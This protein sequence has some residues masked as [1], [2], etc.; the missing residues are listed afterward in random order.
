[1]ILPSN[2]PGPREVRLDRTCCLPRQ[3]GRHH[4]A[5]HRQCASERRPCRLCGPLEARQLSLGRSGVEL[6][7]RFVDLHEKAVRAGELE[8]AAESFVGRGTRNSD[9]RCS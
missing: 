9:T 5:S 4:R 7:V 1:V 6:G 2:P 3:S 8:L